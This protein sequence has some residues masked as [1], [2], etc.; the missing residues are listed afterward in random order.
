MVFRIKFYVIF[1]ATLNDIKINCNKNFH[2]KKNFVKNNRIV[3]SLSY[4]L[5]I[6]PYMLEKF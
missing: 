1:D 4:L 6:I 5:D 3:K 2:L